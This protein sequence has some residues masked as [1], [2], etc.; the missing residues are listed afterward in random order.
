VIGQGQQDLPE[1]RAVREGQVGRAVA[2]VVAHQQLAHRQASAFAVPAVDRGL[3]FVGDVAAEDAAL[4][5]QA[6]EVDQPDAAVVGHGDV[7]QVKVR[8]AAGEC[9]AVL[10]DA[11]VAFAAAVGGE[12]AVANT[13]ATERRVH[14]RAADVAVIAT[15]QRT[16]NVCL[17]KVVQGAALAGGIVIVAGNVAGQQ[18]VAT[19]QT[20]DV[21]QR[22]AKAGSAV[23][24]AGVVAEQFA[25]GDQQAAVVGDG[26]ATARAAAPGVIGLV[27][28]QAHAVDGRRALVV[29]C[30][31]LERA[32]AVGQRQLA[33]QQRGAREHLQDALGLLAVNEGPFDTG[34][35]NGQV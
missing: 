1:Q 22:A 8:G 29:Q 10:D 2:G 16:G 18:Q 4:D 7:Q 3:V 26:A 24:A 20:A 17:A 9:A 34:T 32:V 12:A 31:A 13:Q 11:V 15:E 23:A 30:T 21:V 5:E 33:E 14:Y 28:D 6:A 35:E 25:A 19:D 27:V